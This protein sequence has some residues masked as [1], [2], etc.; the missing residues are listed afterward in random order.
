[1]QA[2]PAQPK[3]SLRWLW[4]TLAIVLV[5]GLLLGGGGFFAFSNYTAPATAAG[6]YCGYL[7]AQN[8][9]SA[10][11]ML[12]AKLK[13]H[14]TSDQFR[15]ASV[16]LDSAEGKV[17]A[18]GAGSGSNAYKYTL[19]GNTATVLATTTRE[20]QGLLQGEI[21]LVNNDGWKVDS[22]ATSLIGINLGALDT[23]GKFCQAYQTQNYSDAYTLLDSSLK[24]GTTADQYASIQKL[25]DQVDGNV[26]ACALEGITSANDDGAKVQVSLTR[27]TL[28]KR[29]GAVGLTASGTSWLIS[30]FADDLQGTD[31]LPLVN[32][33]AFCLAAF[34]GQYDS[35]FALLSDD[36][37][38]EVKTAAGLTKYFTSSTGAKVTLCAPEPST[39]KVTGAKAQVDMTLSVLTSSGAT[40]K[41]TMTI[42]LIQDATNQWKVDGW[43]FS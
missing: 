43:E 9:D 2:P 17:T 28:G 25:Q 42:F 40:G 35:A 41:G 6:K 18:C 21:G 19:F 34:L 37:K 5:L 29:T 32:G 1:L 14:Y 30:D 7:K 38:A 13:A 11:G 23:L 8:Y 27:S 12:S 15:Q 16:A 33:T 24:T 36:G 20:K 31:L 10:Y 26:T 39:L 22:L 3:R 4:I